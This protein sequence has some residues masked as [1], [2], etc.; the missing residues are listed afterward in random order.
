MAI[1]VSHIADD[2]ET[3]AR[4]ALRQVPLCDLIELRLDRIAHPGKER[5]EEFCRA[6][7]KPVIIACN[8]PEAFGTFQGSKDEL[9]QLYHDAAQ[10]GARFVDIDYRLSL[11]LGEVEAPCHRIVS[12][13]VLEGT[14]ED[15]DACHEEIQEVLYEGDVTKLVTHADSCEDGLRLLAWLRG[16]KGIVSFCSGA[17]GSFTRVLAP[18][19]GSPFT[20]CAPADI[21]DEGGAVV[22]RT[23]P[24]QLRVNDL[25]AIL[26]PGGVSQETAVLGV[27]GNPIGRSYSPWV[28]G[29]ALK[30]A[31]LDAVYVAFEPSSFD[32]FVALTSDGNYRGFSITA[33]FKEDA[34]RSSTDRDAASEKTGAVNTFFRDGERWRAANTDV[35]GVR[36]TLERALEIHSQK[37]GVP[38]SVAAVHALVLGSGGAARAAAWAVR[39][40]DGRVTV[41]ARRKERADAVAAE[42]DCEAVEWSAIP[43]VE[44]DVLIHT[45]PI[46]SL[47]STNNCADTEG[48]VVPAEWIRPGSLVFDAV[49]RPIRTPL[50]ALAHEKGCT[51]VPGGEWFCRQAALQFRLFTQCE[52]D[53]ELM[54]QA[55]EHADESARSGR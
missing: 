17:A 26:P 34:Y 13:H 50:L 25:L 6:A 48:L 1:V 16:T 10:A 32:A 15:L 30:A 24:G 39:S 2:F 53:E 31:K 43:S 29:M 23:A 7:K 55:F 28:H 21:P 37:P 12:R 52:P 20:Y 8:G 22:E 9:F 11:E 38:G 14:P 4:R 54:R 19:F 35:A 41:A 36:E 51:A 47:A 40:L 49:Y 33:P 27:V 5:I 46:G 18:I 3:L 45:T 44:Y 42:L